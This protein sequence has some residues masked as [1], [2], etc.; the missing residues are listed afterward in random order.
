MEIK[1]QGNILWKTKN[2]P[3]KLTG[4]CIFYKHETIEL[5]KLLQNRKEIRFNLPLVKYSGN[6][7]RKNKKTAK[8]K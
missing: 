5:R 1:L 8:I 4:I 6:C 2:S 3:D 7:W